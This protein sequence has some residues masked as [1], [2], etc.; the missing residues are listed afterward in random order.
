MRKEYIL[1]ATYLIRFLKELEKQATF[2]KNFQK[3]SSFTVENRIFHGFLL[4]CPFGR[5]I[6]QGRFVKNPMAIIFL[7]R[8]R[9]P[10]IQILL[11]TGG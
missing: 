5:I 2:F 10:R 7:T 6:L 9:I 3:K 8:Q 4:L 11:K 1:A